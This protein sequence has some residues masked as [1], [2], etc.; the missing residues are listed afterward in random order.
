MLVWG[1]VVSDERPQCIERHL[2]AFRGAQPIDNSPA[3]EAVR[4]R[5][6]CFLLL[7]GPYGKGRNHALDRRECRALR[8]QRANDASR[9]ARSAL[10]RAELD[11][12]LIPSPSVVNRYEFCS[13]RQQFPVGQG[14]FGKV[15]TGDQTVN[16]A[17]HIR[18]EKRYGFLECEAGNCARG[19][20][21]DPGKLQKLL[22]F[23]R[24]DTAIPL[25]YRLR[26]SLQ[27]DSTAVVAEPRPQ[28]DHHG[29]WRVG[30]RL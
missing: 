12:R 26:G 28:R 9:F 8:L 13:V 2:R 4:S 14:L 27:I 23:S 20:W 6:G 17:F 3:I 25:H 5:E 7:A 24:E 1:V 18:V 16:Y 30:E 19:V 29:C 10:K 15:R 11:E 21:A 22:R